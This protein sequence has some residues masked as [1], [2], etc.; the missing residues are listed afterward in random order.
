MEPKGRVLSILEGKKAD[1]IPVDLW[2]TPEIGLELK[3]HFNVLTKL[4]GVL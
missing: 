1:R 2:Y 4:R 3:H